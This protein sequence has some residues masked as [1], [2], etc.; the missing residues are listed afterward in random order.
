[1]AKRKRAPLELK[2]GPPGG[3]GDIVGWAVGVPWAFRGALDIAFTERKVDGRTVAEWTRGVPPARAFGTGDI[4]YLPGEARRPVW[5]NALKILR[6]AIQVVEATPDTPLDGGIDEGTVI[7][8]CSIYKSGAVA[9]TL[10]GKCT[11]AQF[12]EILACGE[13]AL[14]LLHVDPKKS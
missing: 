12:E 10:R 14:I 11:Q 1:M 3:E 6:M 2:F 13:L 4:F 7:F 8:D 5:E 9:E